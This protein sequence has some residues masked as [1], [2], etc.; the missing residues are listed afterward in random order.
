MSSLQAT[1]NSYTYLV[2]LDGTIIAAAD[3]ALGLLYC[4]HAPRCNGTMIYDTSASDTFA[5][6]GEGA[7]GPT[8]KLCNYANLFAYFGSDITNL[9]F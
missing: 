6:G 1:A 5:T 9:N 2:T 8:L 4:P 3:N 7:L